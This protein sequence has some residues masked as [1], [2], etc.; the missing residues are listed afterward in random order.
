MIRALTAS[1][2]SVRVWNAVTDSRNSWVG[3]WGK[4]EAQKNCP[5]LRASTAT[6]SIRSSNSQWKKIRSLRRRAVDGK[7]R[8]QPLGLLVD[9][10]IVRIAEGPP[11]PHRGKNRSH[12]AERCHG[13]PELL[14]CLANVLERDQGDALESRRGGLE[15]FLLE[16]G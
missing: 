1:L 4:S 10:V 14:D 12:H 8:A 2:R 9:G 6:G 5:A 11:E 16:E 13:P 7:H 15:E 3:S